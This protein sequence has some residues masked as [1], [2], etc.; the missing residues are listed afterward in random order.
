MISHK[1]N[2]ISEIADAVTII[3]DGQTVERL[4]VADAPVD[5]DRITSYNV[6]YTKLL[7][8][9]VVGGAARSAVSAVAAASAVGWG[10]ARVTGA[11][12]VADSYNF[13]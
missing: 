12:S 8:M 6:C 1:L 9:P 3:R 13:V 11:T 4:D 7:R 10:N 2:E 5:E